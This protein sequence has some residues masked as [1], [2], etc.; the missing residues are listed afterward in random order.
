MSVDAVQQ[1]FSR[2]TLK[3]GFVDRFYEIFL[4]SHPSLKPMF[5]HTNFVEQKQLLRKGI[6]MMLLFAQGNPMAKNAMDRLAKS[7]GPEGMK[8]RPE[9]YSYWVDG[10][11]RAVAEFDPQFGPELDKAW[12]EALAAGIGHI[13]GRP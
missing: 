3:K 5:A 12:R 11:M 10:L 8:I 9:L 13:S 1:S 6:S 7:H 2:C 4:A